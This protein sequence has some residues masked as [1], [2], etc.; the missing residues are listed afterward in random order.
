MPATTDGS[1]CGQEED[2]S[3]QDQ[4]KDAEEEIDAVM[5]WNVVWVWSWWHVI[6][7]IKR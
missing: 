2:E 4:A 7:I 1:I 5:D 6:R 3:G